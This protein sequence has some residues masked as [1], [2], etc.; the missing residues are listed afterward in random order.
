MSMSHAD[1]THLT[2]LLRLRDRSDKLSW[3]EF[4]ERYGQLL[5]RY[6]RSRGAS[7]ADAEDIVQEVE[8]YLFKALD[9]FEYDARKGRFRAY[10]RSAVVHAMARRASKQARQPT[11]L[12]PR[13]FD[14]LA[15]QKADS[16]A[17]WDR[18][19]RLHRLRWAMRSVA[20][21]FEPVTLKAFEMHVLAGRSVA[22]T[23]DK[24]GLSKAS[25]YQAKS[26]V[27]RCLKERLAA[28]DPDGDT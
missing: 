6:A 13:T 25:V 7:D 23:A 20:D 17:E 5:Y 27:L 10:L 11:G 14:H 16:D 12:D 2:F 8:M 4:H 9:G 21:T 3:Q 26:R 22:E 1:T 24:L 28:T 19:W 15:S 18:E